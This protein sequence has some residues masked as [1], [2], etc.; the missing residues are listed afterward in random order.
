MTAELWAMIAWG[1]VVTPFVCWALLH[2]PA[3][4]RIEIPPITVPPWPAIPAPVIL[5]AEPAPEPHWTY[6]YISHGEI[7]EVRLSAAGG[8]GWEGVGFDANGKLL[9]KRRV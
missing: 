8:T 6:R 2:K 7:D 5:P 9:M 4:P 3:S 1:A